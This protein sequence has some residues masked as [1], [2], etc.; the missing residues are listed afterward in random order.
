M[1]QGSSN[2]TNFA[3]AFK[4]HYDHRVLFDQLLGKFPLFGMIKKTDD[5]T[6]EEHKWFVKTG[7][8]QGVSHTFANT[9]TYRTSGRGTQFAMDVAEN[10][11]T[12][13]ISHKDWMRSQNNL[14]A[15]FDLKREEVDGLIEE[16]LEHAA[17][18]LYQTS[19]PVLGIVSSESTTTLTL[20][21]PEDTRFFSIDQEVEAYDTT[22]ATQR[23][24]SATV[25]AI[26]YA[27]GTLTTD[28]NWTSQ[29]TGL[30]ATDK[31]FNIGDK[32]NGFNGLAGWLPTTTELAAETSFYGVTTRSVDPIRLAGYYYDGSGLLVSEALRKACHQASLYKVYPKGDWV[33]FVNPL[34]FEKI[35]DELSDKQVIQMP[36]SGA[37]GKVVGDIGF[38]ALVIHGP[39][40]RI[41]VLSDPMCQ[42]TECYILDMSTWELKGMGGFPFK[43]E[44][45]EMRYNAMEMEIRVGYYANVK[46][47]APGKNIHVTV[48]DPTA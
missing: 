21:N 24:G 40:G 43:V 10:Y 36:A 2:I 3:A 6:G 15:F 4:K 39:S 23:T 1:G 5:F 46:C 37:N 16:L 30:V 45:S 42:L 25:T 12:V 26:D 17:R 44:P 13:Y 34:N 28:S 32:G 38:D 18:E 8:P 7:R 35:D 47:Y 48:D 19:N 27:N 29:I 11:G 9:Q 41:K 33:C 22:L 14:G 20:T 31:I